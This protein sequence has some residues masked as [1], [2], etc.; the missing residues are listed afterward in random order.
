MK[1]ITW[2]KKIKLWEKQQF[3]E[4]KK[5]IMEHVLNMQ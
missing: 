2:T 5:D 4:N 1:N 3:V